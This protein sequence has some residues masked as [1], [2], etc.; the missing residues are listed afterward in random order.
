MDCEHVR[1]SGEA[2]GGRTGETEGKDERKKGFVKSSAAGLNP[3]SQ[4]PCLTRQAPRLKAPLTCWSV[5]E[6]HR[7]EKRGD[8]R[9]SERMWS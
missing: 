2:V 5:E 9:S 7:M 1:C 6:I 3:L 4:A 8:E